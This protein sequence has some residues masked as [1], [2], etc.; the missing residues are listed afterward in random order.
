MTNGI[1]IL[2][3]PYKMM[4]GFVMRKINDETTMA[5][6]KSNGDLYEFDSISEEILSFMREGK[7]LKDIF[8]ELCATYDAEENEILNDY[9][10]LLERLIECKVIILL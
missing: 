3:K 9:I 10:A 1:K 6:N 4:E 2:E 8:K 7:S 5:Y